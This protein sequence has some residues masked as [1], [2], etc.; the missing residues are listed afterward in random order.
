MGL[1]GERTSTTWSW[2]IR[3]VG[4]VALLSCT[5]PPLTIVAQ[6]FDEKT[7][8]NLPTADLAG[9]SMDGNAA[10]VDGD[11]DL[12]IVIANEFRPNILLINNGSGVF[13]N[14]SATQLPQ[15]SRDSEDIAFGDFDGDTN[16]DIVVVSEDDFVNELYLNT[17]EGTGF[18]SDASDRLPTTGRSNAVLSTD[19]DENGFADILIG[20]NGQNVLLLNNGMA[21][22]TDATATRLP[23][24]NDVTQDLELGDVDGD[25]DLDLLVGNEGNNRLLLNDGGGFFTDVS[26]E[27]LPV[28]LTPEETRE[29]DF[30]DVD[31]DGDLDILFANVRLFVNNAVRQNRLL[32]NDGKGF[33]TD[34]TSERLPVDNDSSMDGDFVD[35]DHD[36]D[37]DILTANFGALDNNTS[38]PY[39]L[40][41]N[42]QGVFTDVTAEVFPEGVVGKGLDIE[43]GDFDSDGGVDLYLASRGG[44]VDR[45]LLTSVPPTDRDGDGILDED[46]NCP[47]VANFD[48]ADGD[49]DGLGDACELFRRADSNGDGDVDVADPVRTLLHLFS[50]GETV[51]CEDAADSNDDGSLNVADPVHTLNY[52]FVSGGAPPAPGRCC[53]TD[54]T[55]NDSIG[56]E[57]SPPSCQ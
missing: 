16:V 42:E 29:A 21:S 22:F 52:L 33:F 13:S 54:V 47:R 1:D 45:L 9:F 8:T 11:G 46:D 19:I 41:R 20:N 57:I 53:G 27:R 4:V 39:R 24:Q 36:G 18:F 32:L 3:S 7:D 12:D 14:V 35:V 5:L 50:T 31:G 30:G 55:P 38:E 37:L 43:A 56:C 10:D 44:S 6:L 26:K 17:E 51:L 34:V 40:Y 49:A 28:P 15:V 25:C 2:S 48:Q 23:T